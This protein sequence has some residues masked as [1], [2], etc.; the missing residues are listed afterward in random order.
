MGQSWLV[1]DLDGHTSLRLG[2]LGECLPYER[3][4]AEFLSYLLLP[5]KDAYKAR[6]DSPSKEQVKKWLT[7]CPPWSG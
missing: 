2:K 7:L 4:T 1:A 5:P 6:R 3:T